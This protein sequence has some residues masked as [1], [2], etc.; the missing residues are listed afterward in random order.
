MKRTNTIRL[1]T[2]FLM[3]VMLIPG[4]RK[5][6]AP[7]A[8]GNQKITEIIITDPADSKLT[9][10]EGET[11]R[12]KFEIL[13]AELEETAF[14]VWTSRD[15]G[16]ATV[17]NG[18]VTAVAAG[19]TVIC[20]ACDEITA[21]VD[22]T[23]EAGEPVPAEEIVGPEDVYFAVGETAKIE[24]TVL[25]ANADLSELEVSVEFPHMVE[26]VSHHGLVEVK[27]LMGGECKLD[28]S[29]GEDAYLG[30]TLHVLDP[31]DRWRFWTYN[32][33]G[34]MQ[35]L[36]DGLDCVYSWFGKKDGYATFYMELSAE[37]EINPENLEI[38]SSGPIKL[39][40]TLSEDRT[41][42][43][44]QL[45]NTLTF[46][47]TD[48]EIK[49]HDDVLGVDL[50]YPFSVT[51]KGGPGIDADFSLTY[52]YGE[53]MDTVKSNDMIFLVTNTTGVMY[54]KGGLSLH[55]SSEDEERFSVTP[56]PGKGDE[57]WATVVEFKTGSE[58]CETSLYLLDQQGNTLEIQVGI[59]E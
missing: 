2:L 8:S 54:V 36:S 22:V 37:D 3:C 5:Q 9:L 10:K 24:Y 38:K 28:I 29:C 19:S 35:N 42:A 39:L 41:M 31:E 14:V 53:E 58:P 55:W 33:D 32:S 51:S 7:A 44:F 4:C 57:Y 46:G 47:K 15:N 30:V 13:P 6:K 52:R 34:N 20:A 26:F 16:V 11:Y 18:K 1:A 27:G 12:I 49:Y 56:A 21:E 48:F 50:T 17:K 45:Q 40:S 59:F 23:V 43:T 25:P